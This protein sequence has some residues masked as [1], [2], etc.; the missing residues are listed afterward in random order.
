MIFNCGS[1]KAELLVP[2]VTVTN[3]DGTTKSSADEVVDDDATE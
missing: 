2:T 3:P 1:I